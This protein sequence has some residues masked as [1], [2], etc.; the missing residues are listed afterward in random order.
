MSDGNSLI[1][2]LP[3]RIATTLAGAALVSL[4]ATAFFLE[5]SRQGYGTHQ[6]LGLP[7]C[8]FQKMF[9]VRCPSCGMTT[10]WSHLARGR[11]FSALGANTGGVLLA[12]LTSA[13]GPWLLISGIRGKWWPGTPSEVLVMALMF[14]VVGITLTDWGIRLLLE[15]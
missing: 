1:R 4:L 11:L 10:S 14:S 5:P 3:W 12:L 15:S 13:A 2:W 6:Q 7:P 8:S 9:G